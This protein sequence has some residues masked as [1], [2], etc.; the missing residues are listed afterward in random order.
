MCA[1]AHR[2]RD[3]LRLRPEKRAATLRRTASVWCGECVATP[4]VSWSHSRVR[5]ALSGSPDKWRRVRPVATRTILQLTLPLSL[6]HTFIVRTTTVRRPRDSP[7][8][9]GG[10]VSSKRASRRA[11][12]VTAGPGTAGP[13][14]A[15]TRPHHAT[16]SHRADTT[17]PDVP[18]I[19][20]KTIFRDGSG[21]LTR[22]A[23]CR[24]TLRL[25]SLVLRVLL[26]AGVPE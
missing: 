22:M 20:E 12:C 24:A 3:G 19:H 26:C 4:T 10:R 18:R 21:E 11:I 5:P 16:S 17:D 15:R 2:A 14:R 6:S 13:V 25:I 1:H 23:D 9:S 8:L 7:S